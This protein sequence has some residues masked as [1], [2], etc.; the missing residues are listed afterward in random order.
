MES[1]A[2]LGDKRLV[3]PEEWLCC[4]REEYLAYYVKS[5]G[6][7]V[8]VVSGS[9]DHLHTVSHRLREIAADEGYFF[10]QLEPGKLDVAGKKK[11][12]HRIDRLFFGVTTAVDWK[13]WTEAQA[14]S[15]LGSRGIRVHESR[16]LDDLD[17]IAADN[18][19][20]PQD[21]LNQYQRE[22]ATPQL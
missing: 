7:G 3:P 10:A 8:K 11:D 17:G 1:P 2:Q 15:Y 18:G 16:S 6:S 14:R 19:R 20:T 4:L 13:G 9:N 21:L 12:L 5:G 22:L